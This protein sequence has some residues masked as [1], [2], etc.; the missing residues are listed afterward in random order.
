MHRAD[1]GIGTYL[2]SDQTRQHREL[3]SV[4]AD[5]LDGQLSDPGLTELR[6]LLRDDVSAREFY[7]RHLRIHG[8]LEREHAATLLSLDNLPTGMVSPKPVV[9]PPAPVGSAPSMDSGAKSSK[10]S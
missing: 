10:E 1:P 4:L 9:V 7:I 8:L 2:M 5:L 6:I 3:R